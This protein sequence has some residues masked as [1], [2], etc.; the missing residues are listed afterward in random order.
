M[1][2]V[3]HGITA[4]A[5]DGGWQP[6]NLGRRRGRSGDAWQVYEREFGDGAERAREERGRR[7]GAEEGLGRVDGQAGENHAGCHRESLIDSNYLYCYFSCVFVA[8][9][10]MQR[11][12]SVTPQA[13]LFTTRS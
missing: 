13:L 6:D 3:S 7:T 2:S 8:K 5:L 12:A 9:Q 10:L 4:G 1:E 11:T